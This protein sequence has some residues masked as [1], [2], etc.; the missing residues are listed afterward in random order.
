MSATGRDNSRTASFTMSTGIGRLNYHVRF[1]FAEDRADP[2]HK[3]YWYVYPADN[4]YGSTPPPEAGG[5]C[6]TDC[7]SFSPTFQIP[8]GDYYVETQTTGSWTLTVDEFR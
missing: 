2:G 7:A 4:R 8:P 5:R 1:D 6:Q 3:V